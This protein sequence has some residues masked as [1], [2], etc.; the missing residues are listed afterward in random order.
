MENNNNLELQMKQ[1]QSSPQKE[2][3]FSREGR[4]LSSK[5]SDFS[6]LV[7]L[8]EE[9]MESVLRKSLPR[10]RKEEVGL[11]TQTRLSQFIRQQHESLEVIYMR[12][13]DI[14]DR[15]EL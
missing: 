9:K 12:I 7:N 4:I 5:I 15:I 14:I 6:Q 2:T 10:D 8:L 1:V 13:G 11:Q 3:E